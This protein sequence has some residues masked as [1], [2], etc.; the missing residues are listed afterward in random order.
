MSVGGASR[1]RHHFLQHNPVLG[2]KKCGAPEKEIEL[3]VKELRELLEQEAEKQEHAAKKR[4]LDRTTAGATS[5]GTGGRQQTLHEVKRKVDKAEVDRSVA[6][7]FYSTATPFH[8]VANP[9]FREMLQ[10]VSVTL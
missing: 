8:A 9:Y 3:V 5:A 6:R 2:V 1:I 7:F 4:Q 10:L